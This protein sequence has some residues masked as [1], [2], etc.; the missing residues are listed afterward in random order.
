MQLVYWLLRYSELCR[1]SRLYGQLYIIGIQYFFRGVLLGYQVLKRFIGRRKEGVFI[2]LGIFFCFLLV[3]FGFVV[4]IFSYFWVVNL[5]FLVVICDV[6][7]FY[8]SCYILFKFR[9]VWKSLKFQVFVWQVQLYEVGQW[10]IQ[11]CLVWEIGRQ[12][13]C[14]EIR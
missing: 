10:V 6:I 8:V 9:S 11:F 1:Y 2:C 14:E 3:E 13:E 5:V 4:L 12:K 7:F